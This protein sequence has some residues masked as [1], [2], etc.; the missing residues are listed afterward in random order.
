[1]TTAFNP[2]TIS[3][4]RGLEPNTA[5]M[6]GLDDKGAKHHVEVELTGRRGQNSYAKINNEKPTNTKAGKWNPQMTEVAFLPSGCERLLIEGAVRVMPS[7][8]R[9]NSSD[10]RAA[11]VAFQDFAQRFMDLGGAKVLA[12]R[13]IENIANGRIGW[14]NMTLCDEVTVTIT[15]GDTAIEFDAMKLESGEILG[16][17][18]MKD[19]LIS[20]SAAD[21]D[22][23]VDG[24]ATGLSG[25][26]FCLHY[27]WV[28][29]MLPN[30]MVYPSQPYLYKD[31]EKQKKEKT[32]E[33]N[34][35]PSRVLSSVD[36]WKGGERVRHAVMHME[37]IGAAVRAID[38]WHG[39]HLYGAI[40]V[41]YYGGVMDSADTVRHRKTAAPSYYDLVGNPELFLND[42]EQGI[43]NTNALFLMA[44][45]VRGGVAGKSK[46]E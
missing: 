35:E 33:A 37:K 28:G 3:F 29:K 31:S 14:R 6:Y 34:G 18:A 17:D 43:L 40:S 27:A 16:L 9:P 24:V 39:D 38:D 13:Y 44:L 20:G 8:M 12:A 4:R 10:S 1:M 45:L 41:D 7:A 5:L 19:A 26:P 30:S 32:D 22:A 25:K 46:G 36:G 23:L 2:N 11:I 21:V 42:M 15:F